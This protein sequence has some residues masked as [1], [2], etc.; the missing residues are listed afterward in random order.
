LFDVAE[1][2]TSLAEN[3]NKIDELPGGERQGRN[4]FRKIGY[5][6]PC[7]PPGK[8]H[9]YFYRIFALSEKL[10]LEPGTG[11]PEVEKAMEGRVLGQAEWMGK[12]QR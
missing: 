8:P 12:Y 2:T 11:K 5:N 10:N 9:R 1:A 6:G 7:P 4:D 3:V